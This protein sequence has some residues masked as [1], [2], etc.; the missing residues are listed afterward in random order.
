MG[1]DQNASR[2][3]RGLARNLYFAWGEP[4]WRKALATAALSDA[5]SFGL[6]FG[7]VLGPFIQIGVDLVTALL[8]FWFLG[9]RWP[10]FIGLVSES[11]PVLSIFP[12][13]TAVVMAL[14][15]AE[16]A[17]KIQRIE[18]PHGQDPRPQ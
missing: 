9:R 7:L 15:A 12:A 16:D 3:L 1:P 11:I 5:V 14:M 4:K 18:G 10:L 13:W 8:L 17:S 6:I 2:A